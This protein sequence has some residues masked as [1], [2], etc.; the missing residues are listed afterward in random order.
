MKHLDLLIRA[1]LMY[2]HPGWARNMERKERRRDI[3]RQGGQVLKRIPRTSEVIDDR[4][5]HPYSC[6]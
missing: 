4:K 6:G 3:T 1:Q 2:K 5:E